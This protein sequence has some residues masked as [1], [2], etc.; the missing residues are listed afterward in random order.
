[1][2][3]NKIRNV[4]VGTTKKSTDAMHSKWFRRKAR[5]VGD[6]GVEGRIMYFETAA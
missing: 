3:T 1:M 4:A 2:N 5:Q 6:G